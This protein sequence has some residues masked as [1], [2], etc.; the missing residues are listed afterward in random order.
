MPSRLPGSAQDGQRTI[1]GRDVRARP[2]RTYARRIPCR[3]AAGLGPR[4]RRRQVCRRS[5]G[6]RRSRSA[7]PPR[8][9]RPHPRASSTCSRRHDASK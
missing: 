5:R 8:P 6:L 7:Q 1:P 9:K 3:R 4:H 2:A